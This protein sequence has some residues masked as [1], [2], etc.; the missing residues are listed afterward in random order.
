ML[1]FNP[2]TIAAP[3]DA[4]TN[5]LRVEGKAPASFGR[6]ETANITVGSASG[7]ANKAT[8]LKA[9]A[10][11]RIE[12]GSQTKMMTATVIL[13]LAG[14]GK[15]DLDD[16]ASKYLPAALIKD[17]ANADVATV[18]QLL[19]MTSGIASYTDITAGDGTAVWTRQLLENPDKAFTDDDALN[20]VRGQPA[21]GAPGAY[22][23]SNTNYSLLGR[24]IEN[25]TKE[26]LAETFEK[27]IFTPAG[28]TDSDLVGVNAP[29][30]LVHG[31]GTGPDGKLFDTT[32]AKWDKYAE[33][34]VVSTTTD[35]IKYVKSL[36]VDGKLLPAAQLAEMK[37]F[38][39]VQD[40]PELKFKFGLGLVEFELPGQGKF[41]GFNGGTLGFVS[42]TFMSAETGDIA[43]VGLNYADSPANPDETVLALLDAAKNNPA[44]KEITRFDANSDVMKIEAA[45]AASAK[46]AMTENFEASF[47]AVSLKLPLNLAKVT[48]SNI[49]FADGSVLVIGDNKTGTAGDNKDNTIDIRK[50]FS[51]AMAKD[52][53]VMG[54]NGNDKIEGGSGNDRL[55]GGSG[56]DKLKGRNGNDKLFGEKGSDKLDG[57]KG[58]DML[59][60]GIGNDELWGDNGRDQLF[61]GAGRD[62]LFGDA[63][64]DRLSGG[65]GRDKMS[66]GDGE[67]IFIFDKLSDSRNGKGNRDIIYD[68]DNDD[69]R[70]SVTDMDANTKLGGD[71]DFKFIGRSDFSGKAGELHYV[72]VNKFLPWND[73]AIIEGDVNG[74]GN[75]DFQIELLGLHKLNGGDFIL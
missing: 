72:R 22:Y 42:S 68:Y 38:L 43:S 25:V 8:G 21:T 67:D 28:M 12:V 74:D 17:I 30:D 40:T 14:E 44:W 59:S 61:G 47:D 52:N 7:L 3:F 1:V 5:T 16:A 20:I 6:I 10:D 23:Y 27:R 11:Q 51:M 37:K 2:V 29:A 13:Q 31:Y 57:G 56:N 18:R 48:T 65:A 15:I 4:I 26:P 9:D 49:K 36:L 45:D 73:K 62:E 55:L 33:G 32:A 63:G 35:M 60:G 69:D 41:Y 50:D 66:G 39:T 54:M 24:I 34:G 46:I 70:I 71:Q 75:A 53:Q 19:Q 58:A 64:N